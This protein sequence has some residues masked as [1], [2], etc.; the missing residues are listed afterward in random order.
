MEKL[1]VRALGIA[2]GI[3]V[4]AVTLLLGTLNILFYLNSGL[5]RI[6][7]MIYLDYK[8]TLINVIFSSMWGFVYAYIL[9]SSL[10]WLYNRIVEEAKIETEEKIRAVAKAIWESKG[11][12]DGTSEEDWKEAERRVKGKS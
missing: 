8:P 5:D 4:S 10:A 1:S 11:K 12:P 6:M 3:L 2:S 9:G 7:A